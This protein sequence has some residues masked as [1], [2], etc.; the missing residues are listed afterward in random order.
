MK[1]IPKRLMIS[2]AF[3]IVILVLMLVISRENENGKDNEMSNLEFFQSLDYDDGINT[4]VQ[5]LNRF[6]VQY[7]ATLGQDGNPQVRPIEF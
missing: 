5:I 4:I 6:P 3:V 2:I 7:A 1:N